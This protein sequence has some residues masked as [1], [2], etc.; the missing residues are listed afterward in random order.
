MISMDPRDG[1]SRA[2]YLARVLDAARRLHRKVYVEWN[3]KVTIV[4]PG[5]TLLEIARELGPLPLTADRPAL[6]RK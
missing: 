5:S 3:E 2:A 1:E 6:S 4:G